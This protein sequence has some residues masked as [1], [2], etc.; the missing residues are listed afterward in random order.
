MFRVGDSVDQWQRLEVYRQRYPIEDRLDTI[1]SL[2]KSLNRRRMRS[3]ALARRLADLE[4]QLVEVRTELA[5]VESEIDKSKS[6]GA[7]LLEE[8]LDQ[9]QR[10]MGEAWSPTPVTGFRV[11]RIE[12]NRVKG[13]QL[14]WP[15][16]TMAS[17]CLRD[18]PGEDLPH[19]VDRCGPPACGV[20][21]VKGLDM[22]PADV[23]NGEIRRSVVG[24]VAMSGKVVE[25]D[26][27]YRASSATAIAI[28][29]NDGARRLL[30]TNPDE[31]E[32]LF[33]NPERVLAAAS[34]MEGPEGNETREFLESLRTKED[35]WT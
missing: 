29:A 5:A 6:A 24:L 27:G 25:H 7:L 28:A 11:W 2:E 19:P 3:A 34:P 10:D 17:R 26:E 18:I 14:P 8:I 32:R 4:K 13:N 20:Y 35:K 16:P 31:I 23:A 21:A 30:T 33:E 9:V 15:T 22:F 1:T 12:D